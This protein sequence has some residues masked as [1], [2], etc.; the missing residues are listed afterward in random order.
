M[1]K[2]LLYGSSGKMGES[3]IRVVKDS[4][5]FEIV[6]GVDALSPAEDLPFPTFTDINDCNILADI[7]IDF[8]TSAAVPAAVKYAVLKKIPII[9]CTTALSDETILKINEA[10]KVIQVLKSAN[11]SVGINLLIGL[12]KKCAPVL[13]EAGFDI[14][15]VEKHHRRKTDAPSGTAF[16]L[17]DAVNE[18]S[19]GKFNYVYERE[20]A[21][22]KRKDTD[23]GIISVRGG[24][25]AG[26]HDIIFAGENEIVELN[27]RAL[28]NDVFT[29]GALLAAKFLIKQK[30]GL[31]SME[32]IFN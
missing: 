14:E 3:V 1:I 7:I 8:S 4:E 15:I 13:D 32:D 19:D 30:Q 26:E 18:V 2:I 21:S 29:N 20:S 31:Y 12:L 25:I 22:E 16:M 11:M 17:A 6:A 28:S 5:D 10:S 24:T 27:H 23:I 9:I